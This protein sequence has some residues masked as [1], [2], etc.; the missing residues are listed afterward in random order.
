MDTL[1]N[2]FLEEKR[3]LQGVA[4]GTLRWYEQSFKN[5][6]K[7]SDPDGINRFTLNRFVVGM[8]QAE[9]S[10]VTINDNIRL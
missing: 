7:Y 3:Y 4:K 9:L 2:Q 1:F 10:P 6:K 5:Y 8:R